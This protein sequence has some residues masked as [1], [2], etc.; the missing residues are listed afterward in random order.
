MEKLEQ[1]TRLELFYHV[2]PGLLE[3]TTEY[4]VECRYAPEAYLRRES[5]RDN[6]LMFIIDGYVKAMTRGHEND[7]FIVDVYGQR[8]SIENISVYL[9]QPSPVSVSALTEVATLEIHR[10]HFVKHLADHPDVS[11]GLQRELVAQ[12]RRMLR[13]LQ[14]LS[15]SGAESRLAMLFYRFALAVGRG[16]RLDNGEMG[17]RIDLPLQRNDIAQLISVRTET[18]IRHMSRWNK[19]GPV[20]TDS[21]GFTIVDYDRLRELAGDTDLEPAPATC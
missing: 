21:R 6:F 11:R 20:R 18:A 16:T 13:R 7:E 12:N 8:Q 15:V 17:I 3:S 1:L 19:Q 4:F 14:E 10:N 2:P 5:R 9:E